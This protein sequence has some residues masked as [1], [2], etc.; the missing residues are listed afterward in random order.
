VVELVELVIIV[1]EL[2]EPW[3]PVV[4]SAEVVLDS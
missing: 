2:V 1:V 4:S 3:G